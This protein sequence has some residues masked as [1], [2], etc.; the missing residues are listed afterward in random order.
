MQFTLDLKCPSTNKMYAG[1]HWTARKAEVDLIHTMI[2][3]KARE[4]RLQPITEFPID[5]L[6]TAHYKHKRR[7]DSSNVDDKAIID[8]L[9]MAKILPDDST[10]YIRWAATRAI[11]GA[12]KDY[13]EVRVDEI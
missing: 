4:L 1:R 9:V 8:G 12:S 6:I 3:A 7:H 10:E 5:I 2:I 11:I 13:T